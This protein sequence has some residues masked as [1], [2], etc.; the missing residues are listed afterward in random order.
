MKNKVES[1]KN[2]QKLEEDNDVVGLLDHIKELAFVTVDVQYKFW[3]VNQSVKRVM[4]MQQQDNR[5]W[6]HTTRD[7]RT[8]SMC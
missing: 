1:S 5:V 3:T 4:T 2:Y 6:L 7:L 8:Q